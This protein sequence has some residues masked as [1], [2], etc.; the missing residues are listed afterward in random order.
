[1]DDQTVFF[2]LKKVIKEEY[3]KF[4]LEKM[5]P[6]YFSNKTLHIKTKSSAWASELWTN[7]NKLIKKINLEL[8]GNYI[9]KM[10]M[11]NQ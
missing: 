10:K 2:V 8:G 3:G 1:M 6:G 11:N 7:R 4:G 9:E 5:K